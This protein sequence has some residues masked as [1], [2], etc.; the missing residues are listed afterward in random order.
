[1]SS[2][3]RQRYHEEAVPALQKEFGYGNPMEVPRLTKIVVNIGLG[4][5]LTNAKAVEAA[6]GDLTTITGQKPVVTKAQAL[7][8]P[9]QD[10][11]GQ[12][13]R[14]QG[15]PAWPAHVGLPRAADAHRPAPH[16]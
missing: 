14:R 6:V 13:H 11:R 3:L 2:G 9:V 5:A 16:P 4:E 12:H 10:P 1:M 8:R 15:H 7:H